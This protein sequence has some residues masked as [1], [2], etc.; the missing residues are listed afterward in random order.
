MLTAREAL[1]EMIDNYEKQFQVTD[2]D[3]KRDDFIFI[4]SGRYDDCGD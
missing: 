1:E 3:D 2:C 4:N